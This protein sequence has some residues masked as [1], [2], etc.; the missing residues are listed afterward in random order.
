MVFVGQ[1]NSQDRW[2]ISAD[3]K[4]QPPVQHF[5]EGVFQDGFNYAG[6]VIACYDNL[7]SKT[8]FPRQCHRIRVF[9]HSH[10]V[11]DA[12]G[13]ERL[14]RLIHIVRSRPF[15]G[16]QGQFLS[17]VLGFFEN[18]QE[19]QRRKLNFVPGPTGRF[20]TG[21]RPDRSLGWPIPREFMT[22]D[23]SN[24]PD[25]YP[26]FMAAWLAL[27]QTQSI[28]SPSENRPAWLKATGVKL[29]SR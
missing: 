17:G 5:H 29:G 6:L 28:T 14:Q 2:V 9:H 3:G 24:Q 15:P 10:T 7:E 18:S 23:R 19:R 12:I 22:V 8:A 1:G 11:A 27:S 26:N 20:R 13:I 25:T 4:V 16:M 21:R